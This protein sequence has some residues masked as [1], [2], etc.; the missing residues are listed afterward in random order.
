MTWITDNLVSI[1]I[2]LGLVL[3]A[4]EVLVLGFSIFI[5]FFFGVGCLLTGALLFA[6]IL[7]MNL[8]S[9][10][11]S[12]AIISFL[13]A[14]VLWK[15]LKKLQNNGSNQQVRGDFI[16]YSFVLDSAISSHNPGTHRY[17]GIDWKVKADSDLPAGAEVEVAKAEVGIL[18]VQLKN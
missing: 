2:F 16:G 6:G 8:A 17:S 4:I 10:L 14:L 7:P 5:I 13:A 18:T 12:V 15:P 9:A 11:W 1:L 3:L